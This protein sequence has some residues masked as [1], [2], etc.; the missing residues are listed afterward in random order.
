MMGGDSEALATAVVCARAWG[1]T[2][3]ETLKMLETTCTSWVAPN[4]ECERPPN[5]CPEWV[6]KMA[7]I[8]P[9]IPLP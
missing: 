7:A 6:K 1:K 9:P 2:A 5:A 3:A 4:K 8:T